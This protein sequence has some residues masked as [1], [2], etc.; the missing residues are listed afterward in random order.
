MQGPMDTLRRGLLRKTRHP[1][2]MVILVA[3][4]IVLALPLV[5]SDGNINC[6]VC[7]IENSFGCTNP[8]ECPQGKTFCL[9]AVVR[10]FERFFYVSKQ[11]TQKCSTSEVKFPSSNPQ[12]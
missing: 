2:K 10:V 8:I 4:L 1:L 11:C 3:L 5:Q 6:H 9:M 7:E 12:P